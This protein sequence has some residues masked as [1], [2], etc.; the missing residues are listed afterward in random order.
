MSDSVTIRVP[1][2]PP[3]ELL[4]N[5]RHR[6]G[7]FHPGIEAA[8]TVRQIAFHAA[9]PHATATTLA[10]PVALT[11]HAGYGHGRRVP[12]LDATLAACKPMIDGIVDTR[13]IADDR[14]VARITVLHEKL[15]GKRGERPQG[16]TD[17][18]LEA[19]A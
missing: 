10:G 7:G 13:L 15:T 14:Q 17:I 6:R 5:R 2:D 9:L 12:D 16:W 11:V 19:L 8:A 3:A 1:I 18:T 4:P